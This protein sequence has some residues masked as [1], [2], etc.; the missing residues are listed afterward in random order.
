MW[1]ALAVF[2][3]TA[4]SAVFACLASHLGASQAVP[5]TLVIWAWLTLCALRYERARP[6]ALKIGAHGLSLWGRTGALLAQGRITGCSQ[7]SGRL[8][9]LALRPEQGR[10]R[11]LLL[12]ADALPAPVFRE[13]AVLGRRGAGA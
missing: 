8:L 2:V 1:A 11:T 13:L 3:L 12:A 5:L 6:V 9:I 7:W 10:S 4:T